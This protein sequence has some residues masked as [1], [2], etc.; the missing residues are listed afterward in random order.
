MHKSF[1]IN[2]KSMFVDERDRNYI[3]G[4]HGKYT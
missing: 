3:I 4:L 1:D 2:D